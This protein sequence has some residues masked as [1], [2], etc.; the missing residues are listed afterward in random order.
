MQKVI[1]GEIIDV[2]IVYKNNKNIYLRF[3][4]DKKL[5]ATCNRFVK[6]RDINKLIDENIEKIT[7]MYKAIK[8]TT[9]NEK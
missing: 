9:E 2:V 3:K 4:E 5:Y 7:K 1:D 6:E 8:K